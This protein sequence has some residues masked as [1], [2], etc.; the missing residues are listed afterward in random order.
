MKEPDDKARRRFLK[1]SSMLGLAVA[2]SPA[3]IGEAFANVKSKTT[4]KENT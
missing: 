1:A 2:F 4:L 3:T